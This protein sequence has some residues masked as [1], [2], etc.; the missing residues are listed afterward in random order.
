MQAMGGHVYVAPPGVAVDVATV[1]LL[2]QGSERLGGLLVGGRLPANPALCWE[3]TC[4]RS[5]GCGCL[6]VW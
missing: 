1:A 2:G 5:V 6:C 3:Q 4:E